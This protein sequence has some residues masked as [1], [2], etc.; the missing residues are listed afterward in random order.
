MNTLMTSNRIKRHVLNTLILF[1]LSI[2]CTVAQSEKELKQG[3]TVTAT[4]NNVKNNTGQIVFA[5]HT[6]DTWMK[7]QGIQHENMSI[8]NNTA[9]VTFKNV[10]PGTY[11]IMVLHDENKNN[12][13]DF[14]NGM[15]L[16]NYGISNNPMSYGPPQFSEGQ[17]KVTSEDL[18]FKIRF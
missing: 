7:G 9:T 15:P 10:K 4:I 11:A 16:E 13:M 17:F 6:T 1:I 14:E 8:E 18:D 5:L 3:Q 12:R 2:T